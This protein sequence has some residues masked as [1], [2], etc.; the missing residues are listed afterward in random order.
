MYKRHYKIYKLKKIQLN[1]KEICK[2][3]N[4]IKRNLF[5]NMNRNPL[6]INRCKSNYS[7]QIDLLR[8]LTL[9]VI[10]FS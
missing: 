4:Y 2:E 10:T 5:M 3:K 7:L 9:T 6:M 8:N 1:F